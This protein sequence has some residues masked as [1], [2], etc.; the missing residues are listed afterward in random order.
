MENKGESE[1]KMSRK[2]VVYGEDSEEQTYYSDNGA[3]MEPY[4][5]EFYYLNLGVVR[6]TK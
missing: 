3:D 2:C 4:V 1:R 5:C 6:T